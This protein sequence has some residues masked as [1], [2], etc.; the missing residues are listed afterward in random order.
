MVTYGARSA[1]VWSPIP[2]TSRS[3]S[4]LV[5]APFSVRQS[6]IDCAVTGP[7]PGRV[8]S[9]ASSA[10]LMLTSVVGPPVADDE[11]AA[12]AA[13]PGTAGP[14]TTICSPSTS[15]RAWLRVLRSTPRRTPPAASIASTTREPALSTTI[16]G[17]R[18]APATSTT[19]DAGDASAVAAAESVAPGVSSPGT[20]DGGRAAGTA[21]PEEPLRTTHQAATT[22]PTAATRTTTASWAGASAARPR[23]VSGSWSTNLRVT[24]S[25]RDAC[26]PGCGKAG[27]WSSRSGSAQPASLILVWKVSGSQARGCG[28]VGGSSSYSS[29]RS[30]R[31]AASSALNNDSR[32]LTASAWAWEG[33]RAG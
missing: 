21:S 16:P 22:R 30:S 29:G 23:T 9:W 31:T 19:T 6:M 5:N 26:R 24:P 4:T 15:T 3:S 32:R 7:T 13:T 33:W 2:S 17:W 10:V 14:P 28:R 12:E 18:T 25:S 8:S 20:D 11:G 1:R 27:S